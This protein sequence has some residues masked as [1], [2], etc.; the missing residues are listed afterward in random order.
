M[1]YF[2]TIVLLLLLI[3]CKSASDI[4]ID[5]LIIH[6]PLS[7]TECHSQEIS[8]YEIL[9]QFQK[10]MRNEN[11]GKM[12]PN[13]YLSP[14]AVDQMSK[15]IEAPR[16]KPNENC[17]CITI[18]EVPFIEA[19]EYMCRGSGCS[20]RIIGNDILIDVAPQKN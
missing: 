7:I 8:Q 9:L 4:S 6:N 1:R 11:P 13:I 5:D 10:E 3:S 15:N 14:E 2:S 18:C 20:Y 19:I 12:L 17:L 16:H